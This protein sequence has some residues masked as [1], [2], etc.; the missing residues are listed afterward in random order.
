VIE[1]NFEHVGAFGIHCLEKLRLAKQCFQNSKQENLQCLNVGREYKI[2]NM[3]H[4][5]PVFFSSSIGFL[6]KPIRVA[7]RLKVFENRLGTEP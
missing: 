5:L 2:A 7:Q 1:L 4:Y 6:S 3:A